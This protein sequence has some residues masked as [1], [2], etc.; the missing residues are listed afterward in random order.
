MRVEDHP[1]DY[2]TFEGTI[3]Q[4]E[5]GGGTVMLWDEGWW[6]PLV[7]VE[8]GLREG[9]L[10]FALHG[11]RLKGAW[12]LVHMKP[13]KGE[14][15]V[16]WLLIKE[17]DDYVRAD[18]GIDGF[19]TSVRTGRT[20][21][22]IA[23]G[24]DEAFAANPFDHVDVE[25]AKL[26]SSTPPGDNWLF[27]VKYDGYRIV[28]YVE[29]G[30]ARLV[31][32]NGNDYTR[33]FPAI[34]RSLE[35]W[36]AGRAMVLDG[37]LVVTD[38]A[39]KTDFQALQNFLRDPSGKHPAYVA[40]DL[41]AFEGDD[42]RDRPLAERKELLESLMSDAPDN[43]RYSVH[44]RGNGADSFRAACKQHLEGVVGKRADSPYRGVRNG[45]W[46]KLKCGNEREFVVGGYTQSAKRV[47]GISS[48]LLG[49]YED[50]RL[51]Y[52]GR[53][54]SGLSEATSRE[55]LAAFEGLERPDAP[56]ADAPKPRPGER[57]VWLDPQ[58]I[59]QVKFAE[60]DRG[61]P[62]ATP[63]LPGHPHR[64]RPARRATGTRIGT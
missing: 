20:M 19:E 16:N 63:Q 36:A 26:V 56:F 45:D 6:E 8:Q 17:K 60:S 44:V 34:A 54:G 30:R 29:G 40:F 5:Y 24:E 51:A 50:G 52:V 38:E 12:V 37:E 3:P 23:R 9:D 43:L 15:D 1:L 31:T 48:L 28:A 35:D 22:E 57:V 21:D 64:Q 25:L 59:V 42:L 33:H 13:K 14:R 41:L 4:G 49:Q 10:K 7:D 62:A 2:R 55:L 27:E 32:R 46:I 18:A 39:G 58:T 11:H 53:V 61:R 47:R